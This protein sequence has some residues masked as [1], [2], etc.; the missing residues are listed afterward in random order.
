MRRRFVV[1]LALVLLFAAINTPFAIWCSQQ[2]GPTRGTVVL[3]EIGPPATKY[4][5]PS[6]TPHQQPW[7]PLHQYSVTRLGFGSVMI[8]GWAGGQNSTHHMQTQLF[9]WPLP[10]IEHTQRWWPWSDPAWNLPTEP[11]DKGLRLRWSGLL[12]NPLILGGGLWLL[13]FG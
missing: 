1:F 4:S 8:H 7:P 9:G 10:T 11:Q 5:W 6:R 3:N 13:A 2:S 12:L